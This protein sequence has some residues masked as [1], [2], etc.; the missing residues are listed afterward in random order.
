MSKFCSKCGNAIP[1][2]SFSCP[3]CSPS[4]VSKPIGFAAENEDGAM[5]V[6]LGNQ[7]KALTVI[8]I[9][10][11]ALAIL[12]FLPLFS[13]SCEGM[14][15][16]FSGWDSAFGKTVAAWGMG[17][18]RIGGNIMAIFLLLI[19]IALFVAVQFKENFSFLQGKLF[20]ATLGLS[21]M[22][23]I[24][25]I[26]LNISVGAEATIFRVN[27]TFWYYLSIILYILSGILSFG[28]MNSLKNKPPNLPNF[29]PPDDM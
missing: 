21:V 20:N 3:N 7:V 15:I 9:I 12:F 1:E 24:G 22:G 26:A 17:A 4:Q 29:T 27:F 18:E 25:F 6:I 14:Q 16:S 5:V 10:A 23:I 13:V 8:K 19:P 2:G 28:C 11:V